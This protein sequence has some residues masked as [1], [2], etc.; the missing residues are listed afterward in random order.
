MKKKFLF[1][2][3]ISLP[4]IIVAGT[5][6]GCSDVSMVDHKRDET[7]YKKMNNPSGEQAQAEAKMA[8]L[9]V[10][11]TSESYPMRIALF[12]NHQFYY[13]IDRLGNGTGTWK[14]SSGALELTAQRPIFDM[15]FVVSAAQA[16]GDAL[17]VRFIDRFGINRVDSWVRD[18]EAIKKAGANPEPLRN[19]SKSNKGI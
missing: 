16:E 17:V 7:F 14:F 11:E 1:L 6:T 15:N 19:Y 10:I 4:A 18:P 5:L 13:Q 12:D 2:I 9:K 8:D 3:L